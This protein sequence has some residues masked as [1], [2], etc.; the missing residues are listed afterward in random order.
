MALTDATPAHLNGLSTGFSSLSIGNGPDGNNVI[1]DGPKP[2][3]EEKWKPEDENSSS[4]G[5]NYEN[6]NNV[7]PGASSTQVGEE[8]PKKKKKK[9]KKSKGQRKFVSICSQSSPIILPN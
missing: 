4:N 6:D 2:D 9:K 7:A 1:V 5:K 3:I 8:A